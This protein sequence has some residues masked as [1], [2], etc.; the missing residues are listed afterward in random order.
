[1]ILFFF[2]NK[3]HIVEDNGLQLTGQPYET[4]NQHYPCFSAGP[5][6]LYSLLSPRHPVL[7]GLFRVVRFNK[8]NEHHNNSLQISPAMEIS[9]K[10]PA[11]FDPNQVVC[12]PYTFEN[13]SPGIFY[14]ENPL[15]FSFTLLLFEVS[16]VV[17]ITRL[18]R[19]LLKPLKQP[20]IVSEIIV[21]S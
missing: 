5:S 4:L 1:M 6:N 15:K 3:T 9:S 14:G 20:R 19:Y 2:S 11:Q 13:H 7:H 16:L 10:L 21:S 17:V 18:V 8:I 12:Q